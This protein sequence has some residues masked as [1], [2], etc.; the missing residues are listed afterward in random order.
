MKSLTVYE[1]RTAHA[2]RVVAGDHVHSEQTKEHFAS[3]RVT[4]YQGSTVEDAAL[5]ACSGETRADIRAQIARFLAPEE[6]PSRDT[7]PAYHNVPATR[8][9]RLQQI[10]RDLDAVVQSSAPDGSLS[11][12]VAVPAADNGGGTLSNVT[13]VS[14]TGKRTPIPLAVIRAIFH[15]DSPGIW[16]AYQQGQLARWAGEAR[17]TN[18]WNDIISRTH[19]N[20]PLWFRGWDAGIGTFNQDGGDF[21]DESTGACIASYPSAVAHAYDVEGAKAARAQFTADNPGYKPAAD[22]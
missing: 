9:I 1:H 19:V 11:G 7:T 17:E 4:V 2:F 12:G 5:A 16:D 14:I 18:P 6:L 3:Y 10:V 20:C 22:L 8:D 13:H 21:Y 15:R